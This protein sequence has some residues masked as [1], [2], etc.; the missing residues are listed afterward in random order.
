MVY[1]WPSELT[2]RV[3]FLPLNPKAMFSLFFVTAQALGHCLVRVLSVDEGSHLQHFSLV[4]LFQ[5]TSPP[6]ML[7]CEA[8]LIL[9]S[10]GELAC[11]F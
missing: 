6:S 2:A 4:L 3:G 8:N 7:P 9:V 11:S 10:P 5:Y 1:A